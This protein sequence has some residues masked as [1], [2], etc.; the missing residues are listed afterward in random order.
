MFYVPSFCVRM[1]LGV[2]IVE[3]IVGHVC[4]VSCF[5]LALLGEEEIYI[6]HKQ[7]PSSVVCVF[8]ML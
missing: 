1:V 2:C 8:F 3:G 6:S 5:S 4:F 7:C